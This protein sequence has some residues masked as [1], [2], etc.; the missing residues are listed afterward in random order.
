[1]WTLM[2]KILK[3]ISQLPDPINLTKVIEKI[4]E[5]NNTLG[6][7]EAKKILLTDFLN[8]LPTNMGVIIEHVK[9]NS[10]SSCPE[11]GTTTQTQ[12]PE[13]GQYDTM[14]VCPFC[15]EMYFKVVEITGEVR[16][17]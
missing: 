3:T 6:F 11:C 12:V 16:T 14:C 17:Y 15:D 8:T 10:V 5:S 13:S 7:D 4:K 9:L 1:M 2:E